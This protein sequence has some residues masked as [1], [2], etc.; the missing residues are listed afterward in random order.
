V[1]R[2]RVASFNVH[3]IGGRDIADSVR[4]SVARVSPGDPCAVAVGFQEVFFQRQL[5]QIREAWLRAGPSRQ[6]VTDR[7]KT[8][9]WQ[10][11]TPG[12]WACVAPNTSRVFVPGFAFDNSSGLA[13][14][15]QGRLLD[16]Y[17]EPF[18]FAQTPDRFAAKGILVA[19]VRTNSMQRV[20]I[21]THLNN[22]SNDRAGNDPNDQGRA[23]ARQIE[24]IASHVRWVDANWRAP[25][26]LL[27]DFN[28]NV[29]NAVA[30]PGSADAF[31]YARLLS[32]GRARGTAWWDVHAR[33]HLPRPPIPTTQDGKTLDLHLLDRTRGRTNFTF[34][35]TPC[36]SDHL[37]TE[38]VWDEA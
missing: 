37:L 33:L 16:T 38:S 24:Q 10:S 29:R 27:G 4:A 12:S 14:C 21:N 6:F 35:A 31:L 9:V 30:N 26:I 7:S 34:F 18:R 20:I 23:R 17:F 28:I 8:R 15:V 25:V 5:S 13:L 11:A 1:A 36:H 32:A 19:R 3:G 2:I 22:A